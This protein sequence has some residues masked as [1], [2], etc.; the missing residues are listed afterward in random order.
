MRIR[1][2]GM[3]EES[4]WQSFFDP[5]CMLGRL[6]CDSQCGDVVEF[7]CGYGTFTLPAAKIIQGRI[8]ALDIEPEMVHEVNR[9]ARAEGLTNIVAEV[10]DFVAD[11]TGLCDSGARYAMLFNIL[12]IEEP[13]ELLRE[14]CRILVPGGLVGI[15]HWRTDIQTPRGPS[16]AIRPSTEQ[17]RAW[18]EQAGLEFVRHEPLHCCSWHWGMVLQRPPNQR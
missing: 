2:S 8:H 9:K 17:C 14:A 15:I 5:D 12:H 10:R 18:G 7:G 6:G 13:V 16:L 11:G 3:P 1:E 4:Y